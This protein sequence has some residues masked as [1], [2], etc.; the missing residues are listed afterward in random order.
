M[1]CATLIRPMQVF[2]SGSSGRQF[3]RWALNFLAHRAIKFVVNPDLP[4]RRSALP[5]QDFDQFAL[6]VARDAGDSDNFAAMDLEG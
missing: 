4:G 2:F 6:A 1:F 3:T 5:G